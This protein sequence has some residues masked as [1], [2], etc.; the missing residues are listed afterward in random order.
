ML[1]CYLNLVS[2][3]CIVVVSR[4]VQ[5]ETDPALFA[6]CVLQS[7]KK[8]KHL[9]SILN[10]PCWFVNPS[11]HEHSEHS[12]GT[13]QT[14]QFVCWQGNSKW[15]FWYAWD[16]PPFVN[17]FTSWNSLANFDPSFFVTKFISFCLSDFPSC[18]L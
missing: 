15:T 18:N 1:L 4:R 9:V 16:S 12:E 8:M 5:M 3:Q 6:S 11:L 14:V 10:S 2:I 17:I 13:L 7:L